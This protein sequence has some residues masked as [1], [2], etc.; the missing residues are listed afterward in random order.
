M[1]YSKE[2]ICLM[3]KSKV[4]FYLHFADIGKDMDQRDYQVSYEKISKQGFGTSISME[5]GIDELIHA[6]QVLDI[7][8]PYSNV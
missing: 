7:K 6:Y 4:D 2:K 8:N 1:N 3:I 5:D